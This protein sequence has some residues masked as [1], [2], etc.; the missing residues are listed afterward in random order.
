MTYFNWKKYTLT[1][2][3]GAKLKLCPHLIAKFHLNCSIKLRSP[4]GIHFVSGS[5]FIPP[6][7]LPR[8]T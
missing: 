1:L 8:L 3:K 4:N 5:G 2:L 6:T 7:V